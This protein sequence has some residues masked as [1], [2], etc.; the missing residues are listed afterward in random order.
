MG[1]PTC[2][3]VTLVCIFSVGSLG[4]SSQVQLLGERTVTAEQHTPITLTC[5]VPLTTHQVIWKRGSVMIDEDRTK[6]ITIAFIN[7]QPDTSTHDS[8][9]TI[10]EAEHTD[11]GNYS[12]SGGGDQSDKTVYVTVIEN[13]ISISATPM[14]VHLVQGSPL[15][16]TCQADIHT[17]VVWRKGST[18]LSDGVEVKITEDNNPDT[19]TKTSKLTIN[20]AAASHAGIYVCQNE[21]HDDDKDEITVSL[22]S[23][24][25]GKSSKSEVSTLLLFGSVVVLVL[26]R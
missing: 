3:I 4:S 25:S 19:H 9:L 15:T 7:E 13:Q 21:H 10:A 12:C 20:P 26:L 14:R 23:D 6:G 11:S 5:R 1:S 18:E 17:H 8:V 2:T 24:T 22:K 16:L